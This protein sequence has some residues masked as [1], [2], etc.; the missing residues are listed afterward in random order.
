MS[1]GHDEKLQSPNYGHRKKRI[2]Q[3]GQRKMFSKIISENVPELGRYLSKH[4][5]PTNY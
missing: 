2:P 1:W 4:T 3:S 5:R